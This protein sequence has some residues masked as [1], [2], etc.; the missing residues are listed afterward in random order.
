MAPIFRDDQLRLRHLPDLMSQ[1][2]GSY[3]RRVS[4]Q[5]RT[6]F[7]L[8]DTTSSN[9]LRVTSPSSC[10]GY[11]V[12]G[13]TAMPLQRGILRCLPGHPQLNHA[14]HQRGRFNHHSS[15]CRSFPAPIDNTHAR[16]SS[17]TPGGLCNPNRSCRNREM[18]HMSTISTAARRPISTN[19][20]RRGV[21][22]SHYPRA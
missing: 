14:Q 20:T 19:T 11:S 1:I 18:R 10:C 9:C 13:G 21:K 16:T 12:L 15:F 8:S 5:P 3:P 4:A 6:C 17:D 22:I 2:S 7:G